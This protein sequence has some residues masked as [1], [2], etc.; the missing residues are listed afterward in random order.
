MKNKNT[1]KT[2]LVEVI[3]N[4]INK[5]IKIAVEKSVISVLREVYKQSGAIKEDKP[6]KDNIKKLLEIIDDLQIE[7]SEYRQNQDLLL[8]K[9]NEI[10]RI[11]GQEAT[12][13]IKSKRVSNSSLL[14]AMRNR[15]PQN[16]NV[17]N[18]INREISDV[19]ASNR[20]DWMAMAGIKSNGKSFVEE[21]QPQRQM[22]MEASS[23]AI[24]EMAMLSDP[25]LIGQLKA[26]SN[27]PRDK[28][29]TLDPQYASLVMSAG[30]PQQIDNDYDDGAMVAMMQEMYNNAAPVE[31]NLAVAASKIQL[32][33]E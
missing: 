29:A 21:E 31:D 26:Q 27:T 17:V 13:P 18:E 20:E 22:I 3:D 32:Q 12:K 15:K 8:T 14:E 19:F 33:L 1:T 23:N 10:Q 4:R 5:V 24:E 11:M 30:E 25:S 6:E 16:D 28:I 9:L 7:V 2:K